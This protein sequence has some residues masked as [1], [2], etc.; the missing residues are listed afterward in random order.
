M[1]W[2]QGEKLKPALV[3]MCLVQLFEC[4]VLF[5]AC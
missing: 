4:S 3:C 5:W 1:S 2:V